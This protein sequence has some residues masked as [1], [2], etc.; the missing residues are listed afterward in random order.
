MLQR[1]GDGI[2]DTEFCRENVEMHTK[3]G[4]L[5]CLHDKDL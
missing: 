1:T 3:T 5:E 2:A 4:L